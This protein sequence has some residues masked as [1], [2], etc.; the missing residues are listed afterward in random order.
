M[1]EVRYAWSER[2]R[3]SRAEVESAAHAAEKVTQAAQLEGPPVIGTVVRAQ[4]KG[5]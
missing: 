2:I 5:E 4:N 3:D 1:G